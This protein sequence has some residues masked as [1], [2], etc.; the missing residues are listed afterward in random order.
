MPL[1]CPFTAPT[2]AVFK[3]AYWEVSR[4]EFN[5]TS[6]R[7]SVSLSAWVSRELRNAGKAS[8]GSKTV[9]VSGAGFDAL[10]PAIGPILVPLCYA[11]A[12]KNAELS[13]GAGA[14]P[15]V[16]DYTDPR[17]GAEYK[18]SVW[19]ID[20]F[21][22]DNNAKVARAIFRG[23]ADAKFAFTS[24]AAVVG[25][26]DVEAFNVPERKGM[27]IAEEEITNSDGEKETVRKMVEIIEVE[28][29]PRYD[30]FAAAVGADLMNVVYPV[31]LADS[32]F[33]EAEIVG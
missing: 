28:A 29:D 26:I 33:A 14:S 22:F 21:S 19:F 7:G 1:Q 18:G 11:E 6:K 9:A 10:V 15:T 16:L 2:G 32:Q 30:A 5:N 4:L 8:I 12:A 25:S 13:K 24:A 31:V 23:Y 27:K 3:D 20:E 17:T